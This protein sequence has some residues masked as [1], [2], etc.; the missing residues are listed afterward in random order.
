M[1]V[2]QNAT[3]ADAK[4][5]IGNYAM[6]VGAVGATAG[7]IV[8]N[9]GAGMVKSFVHNAEMFTSQS[10]NSVDPI[11]GVARETCTLEIELLEYD[12]SAFSVLTGDMWNGTSASMIVGGQVT[13]LSGVGIKLLNTRKLTTG[14]SQTTTYV[15]QKAIAG[16]F[17][18]NPKSDNDSDPVALYSFSLTCYQYAT[19]GTIFTKAV[20]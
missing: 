20:A 10:G 9:L 11:V 16:G 12:G 13:A 3:V 17:S 14:S 19:A 8:I 15:I 4:V 5:E 7:A 1:P 2:Y 18:L 6:Y